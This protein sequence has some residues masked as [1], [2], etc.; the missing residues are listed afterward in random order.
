MN[1]LN[2][3][4]VSSPKETSPALSNQK[5][6]SGLSHLVKSKQIVSFTSSQKQTFRRS[7]LIKSKNTFLV[8]SHISKLGGSKAACGGEQGV[9]RV[10]WAVRRYEGQAHGWCVRVWSSE[11]EAR[12]SGMLYIIRRF[13]NIHR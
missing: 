1:T 7:Y 3:S 4:I 13:F 10:A 8:C 5:Q 6:E 2:I 9:R 11:T 12:A